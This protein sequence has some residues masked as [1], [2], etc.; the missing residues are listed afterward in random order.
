M[1]G[2]S[3]RA[4]CCLFLTSRGCLRVCVCT[5]RIPMRGAKARERRVARVDLLCAGDDDEV[6]AWVY[7]RALSR[8]TVC[9]CGCGVS[10]SMNDV[11]QAVAWAVGDA[12]GR[13]LYAAL[14]FHGR[15]C[16]CER[17]CTYLCV[18]S[19]PACA[20]AAEARRGARSFC[21]CAFSPHV[22]LAFTMRAGAEC[23]FQFRVSFRPAR[24]AFALAWFTQKHTRR[25]RRPL[26]A[27]T[28]ACARLTRA[29]SV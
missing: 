26:T 18:M 16:D 2:E 28:H 29:H 24:A 8:V 22:V 1:G 25:A 15:R 10:L 19:V 17:R 23:V 11:R 3:C 14:P 7:G 5:V 20:C 13:V 21:F 4:R 27:A 12:V 6:R 9:M